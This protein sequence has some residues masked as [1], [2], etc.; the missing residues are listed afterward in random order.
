[1]N[2]KTLARF[3]RLRE[4]L[5]LSSEVL[6]TEDALWE[7]LTQLLPKYPQQSLSQ[8][9]GF[10]VVKV[11][12]ENQTHAQALAFPGGPTPVEAL[13]T[14]LEAVADLLQKPDIWPARLCGPLALVS[15]LWDPATSFRIVLRTQ[16]TDGSTRDIRV[17]LPR[18]VEGGPSLPLFDPG[19]G[20]QITEQEKALLG[21]WAFNQ[22][23]RLF[24]DGCAP[25]RMYYG[26]G[27]GP[28]EGA[29]EPKE[30]K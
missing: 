26:P 19:V 29:E 23:K 17:T 15:A 21:L 13:L 4:R 28:E 14:A 8:G 3:L 5:T 20:D 18:P 24:A 30:N 11:R 22:V 7:V 12:K 25:N 9:D 6:P 27:F 16:W 2:S 10:Y 1:M